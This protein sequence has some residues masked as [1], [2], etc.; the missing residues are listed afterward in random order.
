MKILVTGSAGFICGYLVEE[1]LQCGHTVVGIDNY[2]K[3]G[4]VKKSYDANPNYEF[5]QVDAK[6]VTL[7]KELAS[8][9]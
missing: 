5:H 9:C 1:L 8:D 7:M 3:Y 2:S 6:D 4:Q